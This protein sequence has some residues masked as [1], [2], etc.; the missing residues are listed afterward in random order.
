MNIFLFA[1]QPKGWIAKNTSVGCTVLCF[2]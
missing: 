2:L 1:L